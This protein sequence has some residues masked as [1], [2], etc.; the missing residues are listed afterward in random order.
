LRLQRKIAFP[1]CNIPGACDLK[2]VEIDQEIT[3]SVHGHGRSMPTCTKCVAFARAPAVRAQ[4]QQQ[5][6]RNNRNT[7]K[8]LD[9]TSEL[10]EPVRVPLRHLLRSKDIVMRWPWWSS[11][12]DD[13][14]LPSF[15]VDMMNAISFAMFSG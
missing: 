9:G 3:P 7:I 12:V 4:P 13:V 2:K 1:W 11:C 5:K 6:Q 8:D 14:P 10:F 15:V